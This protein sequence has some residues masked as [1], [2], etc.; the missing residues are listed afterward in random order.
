VQEGEN[1]T[2]I[3]NTYSVT[4]EELLAINNLANADALAVGQQLLIPGGEGEAVA[5]AYTVQAGDTLAHIAALFNTTP[6]EVRATNHIL[7]RFAQPFVGQ[8]LTVVSRTGSALPQP[9]TGTPHIVTAGESLPMIAARYGRPP[10]TIAAANNLTYPYYLFSGQRLRIPSD[11]EY[12]D[13][14]GEWLAVRV[15]PLPA[16][17]GSTLS[18]FIQNLLDGTPSGSF[19]GQP[20]R[21]FPY[22]N[23]YIALVGIDAFTEPGSYAL[24]LSGSGSQPWRPFQ[25]NIPVASAGFG[26]QQIVVSEE[27]TALLDPQIRQQEDA[28]LATLYNQTAETPAWDGLFQYPVTTTVV[29]AG[30]GDGRSYNGGPVEIYHT[31]VDFAGGNGTSILAPA[32]ATVIFAG[33]L[34]LRGNTVILDHGLGVMTGYFHLSEMFVQPGDVVASG[35]AIGAG[36]STGLSTGPHLH[37]DVRVNGV[38]V[39]GLQWVEETFP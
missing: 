24:Q 13:L 18:I 4:V 34:E 1:L 32:P 6:E 39:N 31:G 11:S 14:P 27:Q 25:Q 30:Y 10:S 16:Q 29:T 9:V 3:A 36:G 22:E 5:T 33:F 23:G 35:Q 15:R 28:F 38:P 2:I 21:F 20:L 12:Q 17:Q 19:A 26:L 37:W 7:N 8:T